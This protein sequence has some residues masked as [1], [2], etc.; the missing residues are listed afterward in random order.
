M[1]FQALADPTRREL[2]ERLRF[3][4]LPVGKLAVGLAMSRPAVSQH[5]RVLR[6]AGL[7]SE[8]RE[9]TLRFYRLEPT[10]FLRLKDYIERFCGDSGK[11]P[12]WTGDLKQRRKDAKILE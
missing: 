7:V 3:G 10:G 4:P 5:L 12:G 1:L 2:V 6:E 11:T 9:A 8:T